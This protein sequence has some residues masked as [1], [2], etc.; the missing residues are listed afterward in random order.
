MPVTRSAGSA[1]FSGAHVPPPPLSIPALAPPSP[2]PRPLDAEAEATATPEATELV[3]EAPGNDEI[4]D[5]AKYLGMRPQ[6]DSELLWIAE[7][8][9]CAP[10]PPG[11]KVRRITSDFEDIMILFNS[12]GRTSVLS[13]F[14]EES[15]RAFHPLFARAPT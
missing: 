3:L 6:E 11:W 1:T 5:Y 14:T 7:Q 10:L 2:P 12:G 13:I 4:A 15:A 8:A 9:L